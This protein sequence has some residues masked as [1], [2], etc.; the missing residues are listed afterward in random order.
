[1]ATLGAS[2]GKGRAFS[3]AIEGAVRSALE[4]AGRFVPALRYSGAEFFSTRLRA[5]LESSLTFGPTGGRN[6]IN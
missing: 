2:A 4:A 5:M 3:A 6:G 1:M